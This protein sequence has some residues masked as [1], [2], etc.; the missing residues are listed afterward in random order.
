MSQEA[1]DLFDR[2]LS[3][4]HARNE[5]RRIR[6]RVHEARGNP[7]PA[8]LRWPFELLQNALDSGPRDGR[9]ITVRLRCE[10][11]KLTFE[12]DAQFGGC[13]GVP[14]DDGKPV[15]MRADAKTLAHLLDPAWLEANASAWQFNVPLRSLSKAMD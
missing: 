12:H 2:A 8:S 14:G 3:D 9:T 6:I 15:K 5:A 7:H 10:A 1:Y 11:S 4:Q 13:I